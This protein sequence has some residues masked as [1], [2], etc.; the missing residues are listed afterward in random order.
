MEYENL[1]QYCNTDNQR[2]VIQAII[3]KGSF[4]KA[5]I[6]LDRAQSS[7]GEIVAKVKARA[8]KNADLP[9]CGLS[10]PMAPGFELKG[11]SVLTKTPSG[12]SIWLKAEKHKDFV[13]NVV[14][15]ALRGA[16]SDISSIKIPKFLGTNLDTDI[17]PWFNIGDGHIGVVAFESEVGYENGIDTTKRELLGAMLTLIDEAPKTERCVI[18]DLGD[19]THYQGMKGLSESGHMLDYEKRFPVMID[20]YTSVMTSI[21]TH[22]LK[23]FKYVDVIINQG[24][25]SRTNDLWMAIFLR[26]MFEH[27]GRL[28]VLRNE[29]VFIPY[30]MG[31]TFIMTHHG[32][33][34]TPDKLAGVML[35]DYADDC[36]EAVYRYAWTAHTHTMKATETNGIVWESWNQMNR[37]DLYSHEHGW[38]SRKCLTRV[39]MSRTYGDVG[40][41]PIPIERVMD[42]VANAAPGTAALNKRRAVYTV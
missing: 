33:R 30:R 2:A 9:E 22:A 29:N 40:R 11:Y 39:D 38:R 36:G 10:N 23:K 27:T 6:F 25:H 3:D 24:N 13:D 12:D 41:K 28:H 7:V 5:A 26:S 31:N 4:R 14:S 21:V 15:A 32:D 35:S 8:A 18:N 42:I 1:L 19:M 37:G 16:A 20:V 34:T 17:I